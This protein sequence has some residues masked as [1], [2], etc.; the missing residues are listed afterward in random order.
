MSESEMGFSPTQGVFV[1]RR[2]VVNAEAEEIRILAAA[3]LQRSR[4]STEN[5]P[6]PPESQTRYDIKAAQTKAAN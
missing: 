2:S 5:I 6:L 3:H 1:F 4:R